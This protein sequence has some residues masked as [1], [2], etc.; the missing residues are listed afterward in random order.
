M[1]LLNFQL[2]AG[3][4][5]AAK[6]GQHVEISF[7]ALRARCRCIGGVDVVPEVVRAFSR[8]VGVPGTILDLFSREQYV[9]YHGAQPPASWREAVAEDLRLAAGGEIPDIIVSSP[10]CRGWSGLVTEA[11]SKLPKY[12]ALNELTVRGISL[13]LEA[14]ADDPPSFWLLENVP[15]LVSRGAELLGQIVSLL[16]G[17]GY[18]VSYTIPDLGEI[19]NLAQ[20][21]KRLHLVA[22]H[23]EKVPVF[24]FEPPRRPL[25]AVGEVLGPLPLPGDPAAGILHRLPRLEWRTWLRLA[26]IPAGGDW[27]DLQKLA[28]EN[29]VLRDLAIEPGASWHRGVYGLTPWAEPAPTITGRGV[30]STGRHSVADPRPP[31]TGAYKQ[32]GVQFWNRPGATVTGQTSPGQ[33]PVSVADPR[34]PRELYGGMLGVAGWGEAAG[35]VTAEGS[36]TGG[37]HSIADPRHPGCPPEGGDFERAGHYGV[38]GWDGAAGAVTAA[39]AHDNGR[40]SVADPRPNYGPHTHRNIEKVVPWDQPAG[41]V[42]GSNRPSSGAA[43]IADPR[44]EGLRHNNVFR[45]VRWADPSVAMTAG[46]TPTAGGIAVQDPRLDWHEGAPSS[47]MRVSLW[48]E[49]ART[50]TGSDRPGSGAAAVADPRTPLDQAAL[51]LPALDDRGVWAI[52]ALDGT[53][54]RPMSVLERAA[55]QGLVDTGSIEEFSAAV[56]GMTVSAVSGAV[57]NAIPP[58]AMAATL[59]AAGLAILL[60]R[61]GESFAL[62]STPVWVKP[63]ARAVL[64]DGVGI[65]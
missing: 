39:A 44:V 10:P 41:A 9:A 46:Q 12:Q 61:A 54:H 33:G 29:G 21:R 34:C 14:W 62:G 20:S 11:R 13:A 22:R 19:G 15:R 24:V 48:G 5:G 31:Y 53:W 7:G 4:G 49:P 32:L 64:L 60:S 1:E 28:V 26:L 65:Q 43:T 2:F 38:L 47:K 25:R 36:P 23:R 17:A 51:V 42:T 58:P 3:L 40:W 50:V 35:T 45:V 63:L 56:A 8:Y 18:A 27:R 37:R 16:E 52:Q 55:L 57:G 30:A 6:G 59:R